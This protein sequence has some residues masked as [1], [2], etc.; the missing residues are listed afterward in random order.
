[1][2]RYAVYRRVSTDEQSR[3]GHVSLDAQLSACEQYVRSRSGVIVLSE[4]DIQTGHKHDRRGYQRLKAAA[5]VGDID[6]I[7]V[8]KL[9]RFGRNFREWINATYELE[10]EGVAVESV[11]DSNDPLTR[12]I[13]MSV[14]EQYLR[15]LSKNT[16]SG[17]RYRAGRGE[18][19]GAPPIGYH[20][21]RLDGVS[22]LVPDVLIA[23]LIADLFREAA[24]GR[25]SLAHL[26]EMAKARGLR[27]RTGHY[28]SRQALGKI[29][30]NPTYRGA[31]VYGRQ[32]NGK[33]RK[34]GLQPKDEWIITEN[35]HPAI[36]DPETF[37]AV[38]AVLTRN[39]TE[40]GTV[41]RTKHLLT[42][43]VYCGVCAGVPGPDGEPRSW[44]M[45]GHGSKTPVYECSR[46]R[47]YGEC[48]L[49]AIGA[50]GIEHAVKATVQE[51][52][53]IPADVRQR[54]ETFIESEIEER[55]SAGEHQRRHLQRELEK[56]QANRQSL[57]RQRLGM[58][59]ASIPEDVYRSLEAE[60]ANAV[61]M[62][63]RELESLPEETAVVDVMG[64]MDAL[65]SVAWEDFDNDDW[66]QLL[67]LL[68]S[69]IDVKG[70]DDIIVEWQP[71]ASIL[72]AAVARVSRLGSE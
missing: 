39:R 18:W 23:P 37:E 19:S 27:G 25:Y 40:Q 60:E 61:M 8:W 15:D 72:R 48:S 42:S 58:A 59:G 31:V 16:I 55:R 1:M 28:L 38:Q 32:A 20:V 68:I 35:A 29:L 3:P 36:I 56:H 24:T 63:E 50:I 11:T 12:N 66:R 9:D 46:R 54:A 34:R 51:S 17:L 43:L 7:I 71:A 10:Q 47:M 64:M 69:R 5:S 49:G 44:R 70:K 14:A 30:R 52:F 13:M 41:R 53:R 4:M 62:L 65:H 22:K 67:S 33:F 45:Y 57:A 21:Q 26:S 2:K 6:A